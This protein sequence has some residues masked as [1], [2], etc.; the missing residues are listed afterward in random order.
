MIRTLSINAIQ[1]RTQSV[2]RRIARDVV[3]LP[4]TESSLLMARDISG[5]ET[6]LKNT[7]EREMSRSE[8]TK[9]FLNAIADATGDKPNKMELMA[10]QVLLLKE[11]SMSL[12][13]IADS[14]KEDRS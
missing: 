14:L 6:I 7:K 8:E 1:T 10:M 3:S 11:I 5:M 12:A 13:S 2:P 9:S 4:L